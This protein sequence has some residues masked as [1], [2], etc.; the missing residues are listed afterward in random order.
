LF[1]NITIYYTTIMN[2]HETIET[3][4]NSFSFVSL[5]IAVVAICMGL[6]ITLFSSHREYYP[7]S[8]SAKDN[9]A[10]KDAGSKGEAQFFFN[11]RKNINTNSMDYASMLAADMAVRAMDNSRNTHSSKVTSVP[12]FS[13]QSMGPTNVGGRTRAILIDNNDPTRQTIFAGG[14]SGGIWKSTNGGGTWGNA[15]PAISY[16]I[17]DTMANI[18]V[19]C[20]AQDANGAIYIGT[21]EGFSLYSEGEGFSSAILGGGIFKSTDDG[22]TWRLLTKT[23]PTKNNGTALWAYVNRIAIRPDNFKVIYAATNAGLMISHDSGATWRYALNS[24]KATLPSNSLDVKISTDGSV[25]VACTN[26]YGYYCYPQQNPDSV[27]TEMRTTGVGHLNPTAGS[28]RIEFAISPTDPNRI[29]ASVISGGSQMDQFQTSTTSGI[30]MTMTASTNGGYWYDIGPGGSISFDPYAEPGGSD[31]Q[32]DYDNTLGVPPANEAQV[33]CGGTT[34]WEW[35]GVSVSDTVGNWKRVSHYGGLI[36]LYDPLYIHPDEHAIVFDE[37]NPQTVFVGCDGG[38]FKSTN[39]YVSSNPAIAGASNQSGSVNNLVFQSMNRNYNVTQYYTVCYSPVTYSITVPMSIN[40]GTATTTTTEHLGVGGG[41][42]DNGSPYISGYFFPHFPNDGLDASGGDGSGAVVS[43]LDPNVAYF[44]S[45]YGA[46]L[47]E[48]NLIAG[49]SPTSAYTTSRGIDKGGNIDSVHALGGSCFVF[50]LALYENIYDT[51]NHDSLQFTASDTIC[52]AGSTIWLTS[53]TGGIV[54]PYILTRT[55]KVNQTINVPDRVVSKLAVGFTGSS[56]GI[57]VTAQ[58]ASNNIVV[59]I[60]FAGPLSTPDAFSGGSP[61]HA[62]AWSPDGNTLYAGTEDG[63]FFRFSNMNSIIANEYKSGA[64]WSNEGRIVDTTNQVVST[65]L[66]SILNASGRDIL[67]IS[68]DP[69]N[70]NNVMVTL[71]N[72]GTSIYVYYS[73]NALAATPTFSSVQGNLPAMPVYGSILD[74]L[75]S[76]GHYITNSAMV[77]TEHGIYTTSNITAGGGTK[78]VKNNGGMPNVLALAVKQQT[79]SPYLCNNSGVIY[80]GTHGRGIW[81]AN[82]NFNIATSVPTVTESAPAIS[83]LLI[84]P[85]PMTERGNIEFNLASADNV[86]LDIYDMQGK[87]VKTMEMG[88]QTPGSHTI[89]FE[90][91]G[92]REGTYFAAL[93]G[94]NF[95]QVSKFVVIR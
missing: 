39:W 82:N 79:T 60:P 71:G 37:K 25:V 16:S 52:K 9:D 68:T 78:W 46:L 27:F 59:W 6:F 64:L 26:G 7:V 49:S 58:A 28:S 42:Q 89:T 13:W 5:G 21:G 51:F 34:L 41:T 44:C 22:A 67:S 70:N 24:K 35:S 91:T 94:S 86:T 1:A 38:I 31:D 40:N 72:Y 45:D 62:L 32:S 95:R 88:T 69:A 75:D 12:N 14:V 10:D 8:L 90:S 87:V 65:D 81:S 11:A 20:I 55:V 93:T 92:L 43:Q 19:S 61:V 63:H 80:V 50:P 83:N 73:N 2:I 76:T 23:I 66:S 48:N 54:F 4:K 85:N 77:A 29:Y 18:N 30:F 74:I 84:Y 57:W 15:V 53:A 36:Q 17:N 47:R 56:G 3:R 33:L